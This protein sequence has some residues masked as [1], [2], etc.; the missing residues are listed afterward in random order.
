MRLSD[1]IRS[2]IEYPDHY[3]LS[4]TLYKSSTVE[5][6][7]KPCNTKPVEAGIKRTIKSSTRIARAIENPARQNY[8]CPAWMLLETATDFFAGQP[9]GPND[10]NLTCFPGTLNWFCL[11]F[12]IN[13]PS[14]TQLVTPT[15]IRGRRPSLPVVY[16]WHFQRTVLVF[17]RFMVN[18]P[19]V[20]TMSCRW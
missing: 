18:N 6:Y 17:G 3:L 12:R 16:N 14:R 20:K 5:L 19:V 1:C 9:S 11:S 2:A 4:S 15:E 10:Y 7:G 8:P 13:V